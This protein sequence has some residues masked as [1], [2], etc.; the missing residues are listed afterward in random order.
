MK[1]KV[2]NNLENSVY[3]SKF[4]L[5]EVS[6]FDQELLL[7]KEG[8]VEIN[9][10]GNITKME[11]EET[12]ILLKQGDKFVKFASQFP[13]ERAWSILQ[14]GDKTEEIATAYVEMMTKRITELVAKMRLEVDNFSSVTE[15]P[16]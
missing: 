3:S 11:L 7:D 15:I 12:V 2:T 14:Y 16:L 1:L 9:V 5:I 4:E 10:G 6:T 13:F 8:T